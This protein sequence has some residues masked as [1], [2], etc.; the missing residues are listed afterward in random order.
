MRKF[1]NYLKQEI[2]LFFKTFWISF[3]EVITNRLY[4]FSLLVLLFT[5]VFSPIIISEHIKPSDNWLGFWGN[6]IGSLI[7]AITTILAFYC[8]FKQNN[9]QNTSTK[10][11]IEKQM[12]LQVLP[13]ID[14]KRDKLD[15]LNKKQVYLSTQGI[16]KNPIAYKKYLS[17]LCTFYNIG[18]GTA[19]NI[20]ISASSDFNSGHLA[21][22]NKIIFLFNLPSLENDDFIIE[23]KILFSDIENRKYKQLLTIE[24][25]GQEYKFSNTTPPELI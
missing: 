1:L 7:G 5:T 4:E 23:L 15:D 14:V 8:T 11:Q 24:K 19:F 16:I 21:V 2:K 13:V 12:R 25:L 20:T 18:S 6:Y 22:G 9:K 10:N 17:E 3:Y